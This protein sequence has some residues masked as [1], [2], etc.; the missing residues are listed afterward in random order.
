MRYAKRFRHRS[1]CH[2]GSSFYSQFPRNQRQSTPYKP[3]QESTGVGQEAEGVKGKHGQE[4]LLWFPW[5]GTGEAGW[6][7]LRLS[8]VNNFSG[9]WVIQAVPTCVVPGP[10]VNRAEGR[11]PGIWN[12]DIGGGWGVLHLRH[13]LVSK[14]CAISGNWLT[15]DCKGD[16]VHPGSAKHQNTEN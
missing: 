7:E 6:A 4:P 16:I 15:W 8:S 13:A 1:S 14:L 5:N 2:E 10:W 12:P 9:L 3:I 11:R